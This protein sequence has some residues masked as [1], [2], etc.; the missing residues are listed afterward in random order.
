[1][2]IR[3]LFTYTAL[4]AL[5]PLGVA[6][7][8]STGGAKTATDTETHTTMV[9]T[10]VETSQSDVGAATADTGQ[11]GDT[12]VTRTKSLDSSRLDLR[13]A[14]TTITDGGTGN[15]L[16]LV[17]TGEF[18]PT[19]DFSDYIMVIDASGRHVAGRWRVSNNAKVLFF[20]VA[21]AGEYRVILTPGLQ[22]SDGE[23][24][25]QRYHGTID[26]K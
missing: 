3:G 7:A 16:A 13:Y 24:L 10:Q 17:F 20:P 14:G 19:G 23:I 9:S 21:Q 12:V 22:D 6:W 2:K 25:R 11:S 8:Q 15:A 26:V 18:A 4:V 5:L 1:M